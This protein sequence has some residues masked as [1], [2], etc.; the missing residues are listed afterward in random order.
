MLELYEISREILHNFTAIPFSQCY[1][2]CSME[3]FK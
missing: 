1:S 2:D 3:A